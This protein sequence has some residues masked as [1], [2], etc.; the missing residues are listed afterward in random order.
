[1]HMMKNNGTMTNVEAFT[2]HFIAEVPS[3]SYEGCYTRFD[4]FYKKTFHQLESLITPVPTGR[5][6][7]KQALDNGLKVA[8]ATNPIF[9][10]RA[11]LYRLKWANIADLDV[12]YTTTAENSRYCKPQPEYYQ[13][14]LEVLGRS[15]EDC[16]MVG[17]DEVSDMSASVVGIK[18]YL[19][20]NEEEIARLGMISAQVETHARESGGDNQFPIDWRGPLQNVVN[21]LID[22]PREQ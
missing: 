3:L 9:P 14:I 11:S 10:E 12:T 20:E 6:V 17:N 19:V 16:L 8:V 13:D 15:P 21:I 22:S 2:N 4:E 5:Q 1:M 7:I 18:T